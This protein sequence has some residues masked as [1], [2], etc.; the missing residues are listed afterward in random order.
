[1]TL[2]LIAIVISLL[3]IFMGGFEMLFDVVILCGVPVALV[4]IWMTVT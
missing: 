3:L 4:V 1:M 2:L